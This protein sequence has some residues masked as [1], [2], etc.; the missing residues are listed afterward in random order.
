MELCCQDKTTAS[1]LLFLIIILMQSLSHYG[2]R[3]RFQIVN[4]M[5]VGYISLKVGQVGREGWPDKRLLLN[6]LT[7]NV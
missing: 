4:A 6:E 5:T 7:K 3:F 2:L 1:L